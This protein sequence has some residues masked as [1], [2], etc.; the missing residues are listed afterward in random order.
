MHEM[1]NLGEKSSICRLPH[2]RFTCHRFYI[3][4]SQNQKLHLYSQVGYPSSHRERERERERERVHGHCYIHSEYPHSFSRKRNLWRANVVRNI[5][6]CSDWSP[7]YLLKG[8]LYWWMHSVFL[9][10]YLQLIVCCKLRRIIKRWKQTQRS[11]WFLRNFCK[12]TPLS[13]GWHFYY[14]CWIH[15]TKS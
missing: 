14:N 8:C 7:A 13:C 12:W 11:N 5:A 9:S 1:S 6:F 2:T 4:G 10:H 15:K 3:S